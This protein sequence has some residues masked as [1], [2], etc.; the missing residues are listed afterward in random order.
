MPPNPNRAPRQAPVDRA[1]A[2]RDWLSRRSQEIANKFDTTRDRLPDWLELDEISPGFTDKINEVTEQMNEVQRRFNDVEFSVGMSLQEQQEALASFTKEYTDI[3]EN[4]ERLVNEFNKAKEKYL[5]SP[6]AWMHKEAHEVNTTEGSFIT[7]KSLH[8]S[9]E[10]ESAEECLKITELFRLIKEAL[11]KAQSLTSNDTNKPIHDSYKSYIEKQRAKLS[12]LLLVVN[13]KTIA[14][15]VELTPEQKAVEKNK[16]EFSDARTE[17]RLALEE[18]KA[19]ETTFAA[20]RNAQAMAQAEQGEFKNYFGV[21]A[22]ETPEYVAAEEAYLKAGAKLRDAFYKKRATASALKFSAPVNP[23]EKLP[24]TYLENKEDRVMFNSIILKREQDELRAREAALSVVREDTRIGKSILTYHKVMGRIG[25]TAPMKMLGTALYGAEGERRADGKMLLRGKLLVGGV[26][27][28]AVAGAGA[29]GL[30]AWGAAWA[31]SVGVGVAAKYGTKSVLNKMF[32]N[33]K[34]AELSNSQATDAKAMRKGSYQALQKLANARI[35]AHTNLKARERLVRDV[36]TGVGFVVGAGMSFGG[37]RAMVEG[38]FNDLSAIGSAQGATVPGGMSRSTFRIGEEGS[39]FD[40]LGNPQRPAVPSAP[41]TVPPPERA[42]IVG[43]SSYDTRPDGV[44]PR[45]IN[46][47]SAATMPVA[48]ERPAPLPSREFASQT[49]E[50]TTAHRQRGL[51]GILDSAIRNGNQ[52]I[53]QGLTPAQRDR[54][55]VEV[56]REVQNNP[57]LRARVGVTTGDV[58]K[59]IAGRDRINVH[60]LLRI[61]DERATSIRGAASVV[62]SAPAA[63]VAA[64]VELLQSTPPGLEVR[65]ITLQPTPEMIAAGAATDTSIERA[66]AEARGEVF[67]EDTPLTT[68]DLRAD[69]DYRL[70]EDAIGEVAR[71]EPEAPVTPISREAVDP[72]PLTDGRLAIVGGDEEG[73]IPV[74]DNRTPV[75]TLGPTIDQAAVSG[76]FTSAEAATLDEA[77]FRQYVAERF[78]NEERF[79]RVRDA[80]TEQINVQT[81]TIFGFLTGANEVTADRVFADATVSEFGSTIRRPELEQAG[82]KIENFNRWRRQL[83]ELIAKLDTLGVSVNPEETTVEQLLTLAAAN[84]VDGVAERLVA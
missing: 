29:A 48:P 43:G 50:V 45:P 62:P 82:V 64:P 16:L 19:A 68:G 35:V 2:F 7:L 24:D 54:L 60:E 12:Q 8:P 63:P 1:P 15:P 51:T 47:P 39:G 3:A 70:N 27:A 84:D 21:E 23:A 65:N 26:G 77:E 10:I 18:F 36:T 20:A 5:Q 42:A 49:I 6:S 30:T 28:L 25:S 13:E 4:H 71:R 78:G 22:K 33:G 38:V 76:T 41:D 83:P 32:I 9:I 34:Q 61:A 31:T 67:G 46:Q 53:Y 55:M 69:V 52:E 59:I 75:E 17:R 73:E 80:M 79:L 40:P 14:E 72:T 57:D 44:P 37:G 74:N 66:V 56:F 81:K 11:V 58:N